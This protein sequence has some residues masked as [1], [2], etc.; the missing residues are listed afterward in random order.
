MPELPDILA[1]LDALDSRIVGQRLEDIQ[2]LSPFLLRSVD[3]PIAAVKGKLVI[4]LRRLGKRIV[5]AFEER[6]VPRPASDDRGPAALEPTGA[7]PPATHR[8]WRCSTSTHGTLV[9]TEAGTKRRASLHLV[10]GEQALAAVRPRRHSTCCEADLERR[11]R[12]A[13]ARTTRSSAR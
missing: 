5:L 3:P 9:L 13:C 2:L 11:S 7:R 1:Y 12:G 6:S 4:G 10:R 8:R